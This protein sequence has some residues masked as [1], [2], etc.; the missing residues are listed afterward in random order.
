M[1]D[2]MRKYL[3]NKNQS[4]LNGILML[5]KIFKSENFAGGFISGL[6]SGDEY[7]KRARQISSEILK[8]NIDTFESLDEMIVLRKFSE[9]IIE[10]LDDAYKMIKIFDRKGIHSEDYIDLKL[11]IMDIIYE[12]AENDLYK[13]NESKIISIGN[14][15]KRRLGKDATIKNI[16]TELTRTYPEFRSNYLFISR[17][18]SNLGYKCEHTSLIEE[19]RKANDDLELDE[20]EK[21]MGSKTTVSI[22]DFDG[23]G[24]YEFEVYLEGL[25]KA[26]GY[27]V[28]RTSL[29]GDQGA[30]LIVSKDNEKVVV[31][32]KMYNGKVPNKAVQEIVAAKNHYKADKAMVVTTNEFTKSA[33]QLALSNNVELW[34]GKKLR[35][36][37]K[38]L[39]N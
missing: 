9:N 25:F 20:F 13:R 2:F 37:I 15:I 31:Q 12:L 5:E 22:G 29:S 6:L 36:V 38:N 30:D 27:T 1:S 4:M 34:D 18:L 16:V 23:L 32:A 8:R 21:N 33:M 19:I 24:G 26:L 39:S 10:L 11:K 3:S 35:S 28:I 7:F 17:L 14:D